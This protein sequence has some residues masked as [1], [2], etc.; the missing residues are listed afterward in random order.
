MVA[1]SPQDGVGGHK[2]SIFQRQ[3]G[4]IRKRLHRVQDGGQDRG[5]S[6]Q[7][8]QDPTNKVKGGVINSWGGQQWCEEGP[9]VGP[10]TLTIRA[11][12]GGWGRNKNG[13]SL[14]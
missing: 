2:G 11:Q 7:A 12:G 10:R 3:G 14:V 4:D 13:P 1:L 5:N 8:P 6:N 9:S